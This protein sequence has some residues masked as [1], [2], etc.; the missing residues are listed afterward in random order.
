MSSLAPV[1]TYRKAAVERRRLYLDYSCWLEPD[2][3]LTDVQTTIYPYTDEN[4]IVVSNGYP[5]ATNKKL[6][7]FVSGG[8]GNTT[9]T[10]QTLIRTDAGQIKRDDIG[11]VVLP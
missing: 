10:I 9:Y 6:V 2:E 1:K 3:V 4:P 7:M 5:D 8:V 11:I